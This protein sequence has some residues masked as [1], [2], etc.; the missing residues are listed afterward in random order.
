VTGRH[1]VSNVL[2]R[3]PMF[4][5]WSDHDAVQNNCHKFGLGTYGSIF[6]YRELQNSLHGFRQYTPLPLQEAPDD[7]IGTATGGA[8]QTLVDTGASFDASIH[9]GMVVSKTT[10]TRT[11]SFVKSVDSTTQ[12]MLSQSLGEGQ[13]FADGV[14]Y[15]I[16]KGGLWYKFRCGNAEFFVI[17]TRYKRDPNGTPG[18]D[19]LDGTRFG[20]PPKV[21]GTS[22][23]E[24]PY[25]LI[26]DSADFTS[27]VNQG[28]VVM[29][30][31]MRTYALVTNIDSA[32]EV[33]LNEDV[34][35]A[36]QA[37]AVFE[38]GGT[39]GGSGHVQRDWLVSS[40]NSSYAKWKFIVCEI[41]FLHDEAVSQDKWADYDPLDALRGYLVNHIT[42]DN[43]VWL[44][45]DGHFAALDDASHG[46][47]PWPSVSCAN[48]SCSY[49][50]D[51]RGTW[52]VNGQSAE[53]SADDGA[54]GGFSVVR[55]RSDH[56]EVQAY[57]PDGSIAMSGP[58]NL[59][60][61]IPLS[62]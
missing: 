42:A 6:S 54:K 29:N 44:S 39:V 2:S 30:M 58:I 7:I 22:T 24:Q 32:F 60:M 33:S 40:V 62:P 56:V 23:D 25:R 53:F 46:D 57:K 50:N 19:M 49:G 5:I 11:Y 45:G 9:P 13:S 48:L 61:S 4:R 41:P 27:S 35:K 51:P 10:G 37:Y 14:G 3:M 31:T 1:L 15:H 59:T 28:D 21:L 47:D 12:I 38:S 55:V 34:M 18:G 52:L 26:D 43:V 8:D 36:G 17:D 16:H 20:S